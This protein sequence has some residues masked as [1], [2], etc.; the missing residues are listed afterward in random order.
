MYVA[1]WKP[2]FSSI[3]TKH[4]KQKSEKLNCDIFLKFVEKI[5]TLM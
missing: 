5:S 4:L 2:S 3:W 1:A